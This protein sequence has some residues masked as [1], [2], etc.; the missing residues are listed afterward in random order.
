[1]AFFQTRHT[2]TINDPDGCGSFQIQFGS[3]KWDDAIS[4][5]ATESNKIFEKIEEIFSAHKCLIVKELGVGTLIHRASPVVFA[6]VPFITFVPEIFARRS[7]SNELETTMVRWFRVVARG[8]TLTTE[9]STTTFCLR[10]LT[11]AKTSVECTP[12]WGSVPG[13]V[14]CKKNC[15]KSR[16]G[17][18][19]QV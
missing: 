13:F 7:F 15:R 18:T 6:Y 8:S 1:V 12:K 17:L 5:V 11:A 9:L 2:V 4:A 19:S 16:W 14:P 3:N 10:V